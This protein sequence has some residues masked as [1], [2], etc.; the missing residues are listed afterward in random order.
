[1][2][3]FDFSSDAAD[4][5]PNYTIEASFLGWW[6]IPVEENKSY[7]NPVPASTGDTYSPVRTNSAACI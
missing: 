4:G 5:S 2:Q 3:V 6:E 7:E 1:M